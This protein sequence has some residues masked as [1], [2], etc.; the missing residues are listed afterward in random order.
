MGSF[1][2]WQK[3]CRGPWCGGGYLGPSWVGGHAVPLESPLA[4]LFMGFWV[5]EGL[6]AATELD[7]F[8]SPW[9]IRLVPEW[10]WDLLSRQL[11]M[12]IHLVVCCKVLKIR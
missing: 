7:V 10:T 6:W 12:P 1:T 5:P 3:R 4:R 11:C 9:L 2:S 8:L